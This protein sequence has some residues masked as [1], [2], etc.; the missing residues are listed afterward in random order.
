MTE[1]RRLFD[2]KLGDT[3]YIVVALSAKQAIDKVFEHYSLDVEDDFASVKLCDTEGLIHD[4]E[5]NSCTYD[6]FIKYN[7]KLSDNAVI[8]GGTE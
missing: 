5:G 1:K 2:V 3:E 7:L 8:I 4:D 6:E